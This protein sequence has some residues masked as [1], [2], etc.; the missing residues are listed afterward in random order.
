MKFQNDEYSNNMTI[1]N[2]KTLKIAQ[3]KMTEM[4]RHFDRICRKYNIR[5]WC[6]G[7]T[8][9]GAVRYN[10]WIPWDGDIDVAILND[11]YS[12]L[13]NIIQSELPDNL[14]FQSPK[15]DKLYKGDPGIYKIRHLNSCY[16]NN[17]N[18][19][20]NGLQLDIFSSKI[21][22]NNINI[23]R[24]DYPINSILP[25]KSMYFED[26]LVSIPKNP[27]IYL[28]KKFG[29]YTK[30]PSIEN[31]YPHEGITIIIDKPCKWMLS[32]YPKLYKMK[33]GKKKKTNKVKRYKKKNKNKLSKKM[34]T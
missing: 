22:G 31:R 1:D 14:W 32:K 30:L 18:S 3:K 20:H 7:G 2:I 11:D 33:G 27:E 19:W 9:L 21:I 13:E 26:I 29:E 8:L 28:R 23:D 4:F 6:I 10:G 34:Y 25:T 24:V 12:K 16:I 17:Y 5:Y 15:S